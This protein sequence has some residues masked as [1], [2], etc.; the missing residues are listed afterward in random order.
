MG[1]CIGSATLEYTGLINSALVCDIYIWYG[2]L[3]SANARFSSHPI[4]GHSIDNTDTLELYASQR[5]IVTEVQDSPHPFHYNY[6]SQ[7]KSVYPSL[8]FIY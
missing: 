3:A 4:L 2:F 7:N 8:P 1:N 5:F 6:A